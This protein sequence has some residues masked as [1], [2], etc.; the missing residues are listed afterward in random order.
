MNAVLETG[1]QMQSV[2][3]QATRS[4]AVR[5]VRISKATQQRRRSL[6]GRTASGTCYTVYSQACYVKDFPDHSTPEILRSNLD[7]FLLGLVASGLTPGDS[8]EL[9][10]MEQARY[11]CDSCCSHSSTVSHCSFTTGISIE[12]ASRR[13]IPTLTAFGRM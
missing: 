6:A 2:Y 12:T 11:A 8:L 1:W 13:C 5:Q 4:T 10:N 9:L 3:D 7:A